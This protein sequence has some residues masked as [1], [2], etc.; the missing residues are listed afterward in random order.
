MQIRFWLNRID[1]Y[2]ILLLVSI[3]VLV[4]GGLFLTGILT[5]KIYPITIDDDLYY[6]ARMN[7][8]SNGYLNIGNPYYF[9]HRF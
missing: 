9:E 1:R 7:N 5:S 6:M 8:V 4:F 2:I 3:F